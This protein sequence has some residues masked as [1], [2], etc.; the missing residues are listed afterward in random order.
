MNYRVTLENYKDD[1]YYLKV[2]N[3]VGE[4]LQDSR[5]VR[6]TD[7]HVKIG[8]LST[9]NLKRWKA[10]QISYLESVIQCNLSKAE[11][12]NRL[13]GFHAHDLN[14]GKSHDFVKY[15]GKPL[16]FSKSGT[17]KAEEQYAAQYSV[18]GKVNPHAKS[19]G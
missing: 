6:T 10:G 1:S 12:I 19:P 14:L 16:R 18:I 4:I 11:R 13:L 9:E 8:V 7:V 5:V 2:V 15:N 17:K 3:A